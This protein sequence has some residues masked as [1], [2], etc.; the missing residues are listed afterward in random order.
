MKKFLFV[1]VLSIVSFTVFSQEFDLGVKGGVNFSTLSDASGFSNRT[2]FV[3]GGFIGGKFN[4]DWGGQVDILYSQQGAE[5]DLGKFNTDYITIPAV[6]KYYIAKKINLQLGTQL[7]ILIKNDTQQTV[8]SLT[9]KI[10]TNNFDL[11]GV[12]GLGIDLPLNL[13]LEG[14]YSFGFL[15]VPRLSN[16]KNA[17]VTLSVGLSF[18]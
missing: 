11:S 9:T 17:V 14:R 5:F 10:D 6:L 13:R 1:L 16:G 2:G 7:G 15:D 8:N 3:L 18:L 4:E 12:A